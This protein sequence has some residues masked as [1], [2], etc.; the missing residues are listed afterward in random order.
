MHRVVL[1]IASRGPLVYDCNLKDDICE[2]VT[3]PHP[4][5]YSHLARVAWQMGARNVTSSCGP[6]GWS[7]WKR[8][9][10]SS[11]VSRQLRGDNVT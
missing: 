1:Q 6:D 3:M 8:M 5:E 4:E 11:C 10:G 9:E 2:A 7:L